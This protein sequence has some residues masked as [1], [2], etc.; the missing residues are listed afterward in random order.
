M[1]Q[2]NHT[3]WNISQEI[4][5]LENLIN[6]LQDS[7][8]L[9]EEEKESK[10]NQLFSEWLTADTNFDEKAEKVAHYIKYLEA[11]TEARK[12]EAKRLR[13]LAS[14]SE[15]QGDKLRE[16]LIREMQRVNKT[17]I[18]GVSCKLSMR[19]KQPSI[20]LKV[21]PEE[22]PDEFK[23]V[24]IEANL[25]EIRKALKSEKDFDWAF[26]SDDEDYSLTIK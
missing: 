11:I 6:R 17:K 10:I 14:M 23:R 9:S 12:A 1:N 5:E 15:K 25:T 3:L 26:L 22:L 13:V 20:C 21:K 16:Y 7:E 8:D 18:E 2:P 24:K 19:K 4:I